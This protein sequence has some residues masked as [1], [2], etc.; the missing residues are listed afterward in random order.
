MYHPLGVRDAYILPAS[1]CPLPGSAA[2][3]HAGVRSLQDSQHVAK[4]ALI[5]G[6]SMG[7][8]AAEGGRPA[9][10]TSTPVLRTPRCEGEFV[11]VYERV[12]ASSS[13]TATCRSC[14]TS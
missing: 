8:G 6:L 13:C 3:L 12:E 2:R 14:H 11:S 1:Y 7:L 4:G 9:Q 5:K 10:M